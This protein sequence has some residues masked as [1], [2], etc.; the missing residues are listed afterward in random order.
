M[1]TNLHKNGFNNS[2]VEAWKVVGVFFHI[3]VLLL[4]F[5]DVKSNLQVSSLKYLI[6]AIG[7]FLVLAVL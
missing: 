3:L 1:A 4:I 2:F 7:V 5:V 6:S